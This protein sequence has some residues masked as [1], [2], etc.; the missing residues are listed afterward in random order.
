MKTVDMGAVFVVHSGE[1]WRHSQPPCSRQMIRF[2]EKNE[3]LVTW[4]QVPHCLAWC[5]AV[6]LVDVLAG[7]QPRTGTVQDQYPVMQI[8]GKHYTMSLRMMKAVWS[9]FT[10]V[11]L[12]CLC[13]VS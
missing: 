9:V 11:Y 6:C 7:C 4:V 13:W 5:L 12:A 3:G 2:L 10:C 8:D 1:P